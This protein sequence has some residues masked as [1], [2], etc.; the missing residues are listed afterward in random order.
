MFLNHEALISCLPLCSQRPWMSR[1]PTFFKFSLLTLKSILMNINFVKTPF[2]N[3]PTMSRY[4]GPTFSKTP[5][6]TYISEKQKQLDLFGEKLYGQTKL[7][8]EKNLLDKF[9]SYCELDKNFSLYETTLCFEEDFS[10][11]HLGNM[12]VVSVCFPSGWKPMDKLGKP[13]SKIHEPIAESE[14]LIDASDKL[15][16]YMTKQKIKRW[17]W[18]ITTN[19]NLSEFTEVKK[20]KISNFEN[21]YFRVETQTSAPIDDETSIFFIKVDVVP[22]NEVWNESILNSINSM[23]ES[24]LNYKG[25]V[26]IKDFLNRIDL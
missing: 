10:I 3:K 24:I 13:L 15:S 17:V 12:E 5:N 7:S 23:S 14:Q 16:E 25:L 9:L 1:T 2:T 21:L 8:E 22:L 4:H 11:M 6:Q 20:P 18:T 19:N 26:E